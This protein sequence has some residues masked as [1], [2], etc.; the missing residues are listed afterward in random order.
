[1]FKLTAKKR[2]SGR[3]L[4][5]LRAEGV[6]PAVLYGHGQDSISISL[7]AKDF[8][9]IYSQAGESQLVDF[10]LEGDSE[11]SKVLIQGIDT[12][13]LTLKPIHVDLYKV[14]MDEK[15][16][17]GVPLVFEGESE[18]IRN[19][20]GI[21][22]KN[23]HEVEV[24]CL[25]GDLPPSLKVNISALKDFES[26]VSVK[27][28][29]LPQG[30]EIISPPA[31]EI[32]ALVEEPRSEEELAKLEEKVV[33]DISGVEAEKV[34]PEE[35]ETETTEEKPKEEKSEEK[36]EESSEEDKKTS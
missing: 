1:M 5:T 4:G 27:D 9:K 28:I 31:D 24:S 12:D 23:I 30:V 10:E 25:P 3:K 35:K 13:P 16:T 26:R 22:I 2:E 33:E 29:V 32:I 21:L 7:D 17:A 34:K 15:L 36:P 19:S 11:Q 6:I 8:N 20:G 18:A 14:R